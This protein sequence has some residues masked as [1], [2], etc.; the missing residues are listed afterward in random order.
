MSI[1]RKIAL[2]FGIMVTIILIIASTKPDTFRVERAT[3]IAA[4]AE[5]IFPLINDLHQWVAWSPWEKLDPALKREYSGNPS[6]KGASYAWAGNN[7]VGAGRMTITT[8]LPAARV[9]MDL[10]FIKPFEAHNT[11]EF[12]LTPT[13]GGTQV[14]WRM[15]GPNPFMAKVM[16][17]FFSA[18]LMV[19]KDFEAGLANLKRVAER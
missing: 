13:D 3:V 7:K 15:E 18:D 11:T 19:G 16:Q 1:L 5:K 12:V 9:A 6:G 8:S 2:I 14:I 10:H 17:V 4:P